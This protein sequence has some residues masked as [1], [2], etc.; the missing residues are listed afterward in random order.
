MYDP[1]LLTRL[2]RGADNLFQMIPTMSSLLSSADEKNQPGQGDTSTGAQPT[3]PDAA[4]TAQPPKKEED[5]QDILKRWSKNM[6][7][8]S[9]PQL[10]APPPFPGQPYN[11][12]NPYAQ[13]Y[14]QYGPYN[15][16]GSY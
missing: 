13:V 3:G 2:F 1:D 7:H 8:S 14:M 10:P 6:P 9:I 11:Q 12:T 4:A 15:P 5:W 16:Y